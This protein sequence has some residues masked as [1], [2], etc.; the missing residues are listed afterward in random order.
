M[1]SNYELDQIVRNPMMQQ[2]TGKPLD[3]IH[4]LRT[5]THFIWQ[6]C[7][8]VRSGKNNICKSGLFQWTGFRCSYR[9]HDDKWTSIWRIMSL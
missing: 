2:E 7:V 5:V 1:D 4:D 3:R 6:H 9:V 8:H